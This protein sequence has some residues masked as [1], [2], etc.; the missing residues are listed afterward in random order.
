MKEKKKNWVLGWILIGISVIFLLVMLVL[1]LIYVLATAFGEGIGV[2]VA[3]VTDKYAK[4]AI[5]LTIEVTV[6]AVL[7][8]TIFGLAAS[9]CITRFQFRGKKIISSLIDLPLTVSPIIAGLV[10]ADLWTSV[11]VI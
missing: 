6:I 3:A 4:R 5:A 8:N 9:W 2:F 10:C 1:P 7:V 11:C